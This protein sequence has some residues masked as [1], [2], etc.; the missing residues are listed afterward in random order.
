[1]LELEGLLRITGEK[2]ET[3]DLTGEGSRLRADIG[4]LSVRRP[5]L[6]LVR[7]SLVL[8][9]RLARLLTQRKLTLLVTRAGDPLVELGAQARGGVVERLLRMPRVRIFRRK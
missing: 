8:V 1:V 7:S 5:T 6:R 4:S 3:I 9:R 2:G